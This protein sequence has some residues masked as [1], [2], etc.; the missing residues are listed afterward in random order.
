YE[1]AATR[2]AP[3]GLFCQ[4]L[5]LYQLT[6]D[7][8]D[9]IVRTFSAVF[10]EAS[11]W[12]ADFYPDRPVVAL[13]G[14]IGPRPVELARVDA[15][16]DAIPDALRDPFVTSS[17]ALAMLYAGDL[18]SVADLFAAAP[19]NTDDRPVIEFLAPRLTR[20]SRDGDKDWFT[21]EP[22][23]AFYETLA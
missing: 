2:L 7:E 15:R 21:G 13:I 9:V 22:L 1:T 5:P 16:L 23:A 10:P 14:S 19:L 12:R 4:W 20:M 8:F 17:E 3:G 11:L 18:T 6:R